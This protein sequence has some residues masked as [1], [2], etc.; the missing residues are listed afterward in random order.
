[1][2]LLEENRPSRSGATWWIF[3]ESFSAA[4]GTLT[5]ARVSANGAASFLENDID[6]APATLRLRRGGSKLKP[7]AGREAETSLSRVW[8]LHTMHRSPGGQ[9][10]TKGK[11]STIFC[12]RTRKSRGQ[13]ENFGTV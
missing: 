13:S 6:T 5:C 4:V 1:M 7:E 11:H 8:C 2:V 3:F 10:R 9:R 12:K